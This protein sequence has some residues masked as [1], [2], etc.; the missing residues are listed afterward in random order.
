MDSLRYAPQPGH[1]ERVVF[2]VAAGRSRLGAVPRRVV[3]N[4][5]ADRRVHRDELEIVALLPPVPEI[6]VCLRGERATDRGVYAAAA[7]GADPG[8]P[9]RLVPVTDAQLE[10]LDELYAFVDSRR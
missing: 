4:M 10:G 9:L 8:E 2:E 7:Q 1:P 5:V 3:D 6:L